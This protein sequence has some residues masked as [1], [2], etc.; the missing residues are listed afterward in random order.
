MTDCDKHIFLRVLWG[1]KGRNPS[2]ELG[3]HG[4]FLEEVKSKLTFEN[5]VGL[6]LVREGSQVVQAKE[7]ARAMSPKQEKVQCFKGTEKLT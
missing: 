3:D 4:M 6:K 2:P 7:I 5:W 1:H